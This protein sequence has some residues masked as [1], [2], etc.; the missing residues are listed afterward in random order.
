MRCEIVSEIRFT[1]RRS[2]FLIFVLS[3][4]LQSSGQLV[5]SPPHTPQQSTTLLPPGTPA[6]SVISILPV[7]V[8]VGVG[9][10]NAGVLD[11]CGVAVTC[12]VAVAS[13]V[14]VNVGS[15]VAVE[16]GRGGEVR[17]AVTVGVDVRVAVWVG[18][19]V[20]VDV[21]VT[22]GVLVAVIVGVTVAVADGVAVAVFAGVEVRV[23]VTVGVGV[24]H[25]LELL[26]AVT[27]ELLSV[28]VTLEVNATGKSDLP[29]TIESDPKRSASNGPLLGK[30]VPCPQFLPSDE[31]PVAPLNLLLEPIASVLSP[32]SN[33]K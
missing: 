23:A 12:S 7:G 10:G 22:V 30:C 2:C 31:H 32:P 8:A 20:A 4:S 16:V 1:S 13:G 29:G 6:Q 3:I 25:A 15:G 17:V 19:F 18:V 28:Q 26:V 14:A 9:V 21:A 33:P 24:A 11:G 27:D 5:P